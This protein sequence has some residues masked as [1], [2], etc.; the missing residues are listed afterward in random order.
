MKRFLGANRRVRRGAVV[1]QVAVM[2][3]VILGMGALA[4]DV[5]SM[6]AT[7]TELQAAADS[8]AL[9][10]AQR[11][12]GDDSG[13]SPSILAK[14]TAADYAGRH[15]VAGAAVKLDPADVEL[16]RA[17]AVGGRWEFSPVAGGFDCVRVVVRKTESSSNGPLTL[18]F[19]NIFGVG[20]KDLWARATA[21]LIPR[22]IAVVIDLSGSMTDDS[23]PTT[24][25]RNDGGYCN[26]RDIWCALNGPEAPRPYEPAAETESAYAS[27]TGPVYGIMSQWGTPLLPGAYSVGSDPGLILIQNK[28]NVSGD[29]LT[30]LT[31]SLTSRGYNSAERAALLTKVTTSGNDNDA[32]R[33]RN[34]IGVLLGLAT[35]KSGKSGSTMGSG[36]DG[37]D[38]IE[39]NEVTWTSRP[40]Y[41]VNWQWSDYVSWMQSNGGTFR[42]RYGPKSLVQFILSD[43]RMYSETNNL[44][45]T[46]QQPL[47]A[48]KDAVQTLADTITAMD[49]PDHLSLETFA[50][51]AVHE[52]NLTDDLSTIPNRLYQRQ[53]GHFNETTNIGGGLQKAI[54]EL[55][56]NRARAS[57][58][59]M[60]VLMSDGVPNVDERGN[61]DAGGGPGRAWALAQADVAADK[62]FTIYTVSVGAGADRPLMQAIAS[63]TYGQEFYAAGSPEEYAEELERI[64]RSLGGRRPVALIQ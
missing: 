1:V 4:I 8:A 52:V 64:F 24:W 39:T 6:Y 21:M 25:N 23:L 27:D 58:K 14:E 51:S 3:T 36:G 30:K 11:L 29:A 19:A 17:Q 2:S 10:A 28:Q 61:Y 48:V 45:Q 56:S 47:R 5:G 15:K 13:V 60:I 53:A 55:Q 12:M 43:R 20:K 38:L 34:R 33:Q 7:Q 57:A 54:A 37:D 35:W 44:W 9:A 62:G 16:G 41:A 40:S 59:K 26:A 18:G 31:A 22:D 49:S 32:A 42:Y 63:T 50:T 46:P